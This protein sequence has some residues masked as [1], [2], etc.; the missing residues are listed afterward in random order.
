MTT[1]HVAGYFLVSV[2]EEAIHVLMTPGHHNPT[3][4]CILFA[5]RRHKFLSGEDENKLRTLR[6]AEYVRRDVQKKTGS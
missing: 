1:L 4:V 6:G 2:I 3:C 5:E